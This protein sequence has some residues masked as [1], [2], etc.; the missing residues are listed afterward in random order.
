MSVC[1]KQDDYVTE[2]EIGRAT[3]SWRVKLS[4]GETVI[5]DDGRPGCDT[6]QA[7]LRLRDHL[8][9]NKL[10][11][12]KMWLQFRSNVQDPILPENADGYYFCKQALGFLT[13]S[14]KTFHF[15]L[16]G[17]LINDKLV[18]HRWKVPELVRVEQELRDPLLA[19]DCL[20]LKNGAK[21]DGKDK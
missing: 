18:V 13:G 8:A 17:A 10:S 9:A 11:I 20:I 21:I 2:L 4:N 16:L 1:L 6:P 3:A 5:Q 15:Y 7:W 14:E 12:V 19:G